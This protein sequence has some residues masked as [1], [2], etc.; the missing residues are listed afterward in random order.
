MC[1]S[2]SRIETP[3]S[4]TPSSR[5]PRPVFSQPLKIDHNRSTLDTTQCATYTELIVTDTKNPH[6]IGTQLR[7]SDGKLSKIEAL[8]TQ[9]GD[10]AFSTTSTLFTRPRGRRVGHHPREGQGHPGGDPSRRRCVS[11]S[12]QQQVGHRAVGHTMC[13]LEGSWYTGKFLAND[14]C[15]IG[16]PSGVVINKRRYVIDETVGAVDA[17]VNFS[18]RPDSHEFRV[19]KGKL[20]VRAHHHR[21]EEYHHQALGALK[22]LAMARRS[23]WSPFESGTECTRRKGK[24]LMKPTYSVFDTF[25]VRSV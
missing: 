15:N 19:E 5:T 7:F 17:F 14:T 11:R 21:D 16:V 6:V 22:P 12:L 24:A 8:V 13:E 20:P 2:L 18:T 23:P 25:L 9:Q 1:C 3:T 10:W 4:R